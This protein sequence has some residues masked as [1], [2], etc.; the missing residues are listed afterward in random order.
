M[1]NKQL[2][3]LYG[4]KYNPFQP[5]IPVEALWNRPGVDT[6]AARVEGLAQIGGFALLSGDTGLGKSKALWILA[7]RLD[8]SPELVVKSMERPQSNL[9]D[10]Y[11]E[12]GDLFGVNLS[13]SNRYGG[14]KALRIRWR[15]HIKSSLLRP[16][17]LIDEAQEMGSH[18]LTELRLLGSANF[19]S[20]CLLTTV[21]AEDTRLTER[22]QERA[23]LPVSSRIRTRCNLEPLSRDDLLDF[24]NWSLE[25]AG[26]SHLMAQGLKLALC[27]HAVGNL[28]ILCNMSAELLVA[29]VEQQLPTLDEDLFF[30]VFSKAKKKRT[31]KDKRHRTTR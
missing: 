7:E 6:F 1:N 12:L 23:L 21:L 2:Q 30:S 28:R 25:Q 10:F 18:S 17:L 5:N 24:I 22:L 15:S 29:A 8:L 19:D 16:V 20:Q 31:S 9:G 13:P 14:F 27:E 3:A 11:R 26:A 4:L